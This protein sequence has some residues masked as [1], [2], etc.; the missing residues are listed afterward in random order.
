MRYGSESQHVVADC[1]SASVLLSICFATGN[2]RQEADRET[3]Y[4]IQGRQQARKLSGPDTC[5]LVSNKSYGRSFENTHDTSLSIKLE[6]GS[7]FQL[8]DRR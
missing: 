8:G 3:V 2:P 5:H 7:A 1:P 6:A 4:H